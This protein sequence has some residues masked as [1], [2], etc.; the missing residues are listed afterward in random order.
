M[1]LCLVIGK[2]ASNIKA[3]NVKDYILGATVAQDIS[4]RDWQKEKNGGQFL[5]GKV[6][7]KNIFF[8]FTTSWTALT[9][10]PHRQYINTFYIAI[11]TW[12]ETSLNYIFI[13]TSTNNFKK[14]H[15][16]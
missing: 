13:N 14:S 10:T 11:V 15:F 12:S 3:A 8:L 9:T 16:F 1:E 2:T 6:S 7:T 4:A 5:L